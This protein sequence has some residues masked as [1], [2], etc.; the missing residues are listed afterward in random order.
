M[1]LD[2]RELFERVATQAKALPRHVRRQLIIYLQDMSCANCRSFQAG[3]C[4]LSGGKTPPP[5]VLSSGCKLFDY[6]VPF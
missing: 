1:A 5:A 2:D 3:G 4:L 6:D